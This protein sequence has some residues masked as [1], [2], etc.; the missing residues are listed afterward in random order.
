VKSR[1]YIAYLQ[2]RVKDS[3]EV[4]SYRVTDIPPR[5]SVDAAFAMS[6][7]RSFEA[8]PVCASHQQDGASIYLI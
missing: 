5:L 6:D 1:M 4:S 3:G 2:I 7:I 8:G